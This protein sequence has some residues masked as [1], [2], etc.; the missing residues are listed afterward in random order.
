MYCMVLRCRQDG[1]IDTHE[2]P[3]K[4]FGARREG[5]PGSYGVS[6]GSMRV[7]FESSDMAIEFTSVSVG[8]IV[9]LLGVSAFFSSSEIAVFSLSADW[10]ASQVAA[11]DQRA[12]SLQELLDHPHRLLVTILVGNNVVNIAISSII[13]AVVVGR[14]P[15]GS[16]VAVATV[17]ASFIVLVFG[18]IIPKSY[19]LGNAEQWALRV[20]RP[21]RVTEVGLLPLVIVFDTITRRVSVAFGGDQH[22]ERPYTTDGT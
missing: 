4:G 2:S 1:P 12:V 19:G 9:V 13:T 11:G 20:A 18:E 3:P 8:A 22:I 6:G 10:V 17:A 21:L 5:T 7:M 16:A 15:A 14:L